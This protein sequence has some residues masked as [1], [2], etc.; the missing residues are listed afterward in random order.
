MKEC[1]GFRD[2]ISKEIQNTHVTIYPFLKDSNLLKFLM[3]KLDY[4]IRFLGNIMEL[5]FY[6]ISSS[7]WQT[8]EQPRWLQKPD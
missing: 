5:I 3:L 1:N 6:K 2:M 7:T 4:S 8:H